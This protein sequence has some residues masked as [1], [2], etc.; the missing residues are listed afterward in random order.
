[1]KIYVVTS[2]VNG[3][4]EV[5]KVFT[6]HRLAELYRDHVPLG[7]IETHDIEDRE[8]VPTYILQARYFPVKRNL[9]YHV[10]RYSSLDNPL[11]D[12]D[13]PCFFND[14]QEDYHYLT[15]SKVMAHPKMPSEAA[16]DLLKYM[17]SLWDR[18]EHHRMVDGWDSQM[19]NDW[20]TTT[21]NPRDYEWHGVK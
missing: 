12:S 8:S 19:L 1:M 3:S 18:Y 10:N 20:L 21:V 16:V 15:V 17:V 13:F 11:K 4:R 14:L 9:R 6:D 2:H 7:L 5:A